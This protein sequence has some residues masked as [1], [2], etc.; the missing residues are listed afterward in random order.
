MFALGMVAI[1]I[2]GAF[3]LFGGVGFVAKTLLSS[4]FWMLAC[5]VLSGFLPYSLASTWLGLWP[6][7]KIAKAPAGETA[8]QLA[9]RTAANAEIVANNMII[10]K[11]TAVLLPIA[12]L[13]TT[14][15]GWMTLKTMKTK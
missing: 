5:G 7:K 13:A 12:A 15:F 2:V 4:A 3:L 8:E 11:S 14:L 9:A 10:R 1:V 6:S